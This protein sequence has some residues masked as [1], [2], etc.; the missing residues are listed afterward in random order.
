MVQWSYYFLV[1]LLGCI[2][3]YDID[4]AFSDFSSLTYSNQY[5]DLLPW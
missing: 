3:T 1:S 2:T 5:Q 4:E